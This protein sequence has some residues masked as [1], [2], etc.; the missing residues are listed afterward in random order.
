VVDV[1]VEEESARNLVGCGQILP[2][3][4]IVIVDPESRTPCP[5]D[6]VGEIW[7]AGQSV[8]QGY[9]NQLDETEHTFRSHLADTGEGPFLRTGDLG[10]L[11]DGQLFITGRLKDLIIID[12]RNHYPQDIEQTVEQSHASIRPGCC[13]AFSVDV[14][15][16]EQLVV[17]AEVEH[18]WRP[19]RSR[20]LAVKD[21]VRTIRQAVAEHYEV[22]VYA[23]WLLKAGSIPKT[24][25]GKIQRHACRFSFLART[26][27]E[28][29]E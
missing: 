19:E 25:S 17:V 22:Q 10:F 2:D 8:A 27:D 26:L 24:S 15:G 20:A 9:W 16:K 21:V 18:R 11:R 6:Q 5:P 3:Q 29:E 12:G 4:K 14:E 23:A 28:L 1:S 13:A 7:V